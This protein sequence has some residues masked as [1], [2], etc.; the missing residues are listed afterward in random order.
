MDAT[1]KST[2]YGGSC[3][4][5][6]REL[7]RL[8]EVGADVRL[9]ARLADPADEDMDSA[10][11]YLVPILNSAGLGAPAFIVD[12]ELAVTTLGHPAHN[13]SLEPFEVALQELK[14]TVRWPHS[15]RQL[16]W[17][18]HGRCPSERT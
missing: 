12:V 5:G 2:P 6:P 11:G 13:V 17:N 14:S 18:C 10:K 8:D 3:P 15:G 7:N 1:H 16:S 9:R 4:G